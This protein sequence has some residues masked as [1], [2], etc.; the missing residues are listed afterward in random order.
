MTIE[1]KRA[2][3]IKGSNLTPNSESEE[4]LRTDPRGIL[5]MWEEPRKQARYIMS[6]DPTVGI[7]GWSRSTRHE[8]DHKVD[9]GALS[10]IR[11]DA[12]RMPLMKDGAPDI[13]PKTKEQRFIYRDLQVAEFAAPIDAVEFARIANLVGRIY[14]GDQEDQCEF[15]FESYPGPGMLTLQ[16][17]L[18]LNYSNLWHWEYLDAEAQA[19][20]RI[21][22]RSF[23]ESQKLLWFRAK[24]HLMERRIKIP[25][26]WALE[27]Y[28]NAVLDPVKMRAK[29]D[30]GYHDDRIQAI[31]MGMWAAHKWAYD[32]ERSWEPVTEAPEVDWQRVAPT[33]GEVFNHRAA[34]ADVID[35]WFD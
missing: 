27:E 9:N 11:V 34:W 7:T 26:P 25:S 17:L 32:P 19:T 15:I 31:N 14:A 33:L 18:R 10:V 29:A 35:G 5:W 21:G 2:Y 13:D 8:G 22:W 23:T 28:S 30:Y 3:H 4:S 24:R 6:G 20:S 16:E 1:Y 12:F